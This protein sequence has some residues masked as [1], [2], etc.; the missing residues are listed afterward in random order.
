MNLGGPAYQVSLLSGGRLDLQRYETLLVHG[1]LPTG[2]ES[3]ADLAAR[4]GAH[5]VYVDSLRQPVHPGADARALRRLIGI[6]HAFR[7]H[8][9]HTHTAKAGFLGRTAALTLRPRPKIVHTFHGHVLRG[10]FGPVKTRSYLQL[11]RALARRSDRLIGVSEQTVDELVELGVAPRERF[12][13]IPLGLDLSAFLAIDGSGRLRARE[14]L[15]LPADAVIASFVGRFAAIKR[16]DVLLDGVA[17]AAARGAP[18]HLAIIGDG[19]SRPTLEAR[20]ARL[21]I[22]EAV[23]FLG[24][25]RDLPLIAAAADF[26]VLASDNEGTPVSLIEAAAGGLPAVATA[27]GGVPSVVTPQSGALVPP[28]DAQALGR[29]I[30]AMAGDDGRRVEMGRAARR[31]VEAR[32]GAERLVADIERLYEELLDSRD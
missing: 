25:R 21:G 30:A 28:G 24:Y 8:I 16:L 7:P 23:S 3:M 31:H 26:A 17:A 20:A 13:V 1:S 5:T 19:E 32:F 27:V 10:Y 11:E 2:E 6:C 18:V 22:T 15:G 9:V 29:E 4:E 12:R 14:Q